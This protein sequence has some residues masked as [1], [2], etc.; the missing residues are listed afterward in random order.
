MATPRTSAADD[1]RPRGLARDPEF[2]KLWVGQAISDLGDQIS[3]LA[4]PLTALLVLHASAFE[5]GLLSAAAAAPIA[6]FTLFVG[7]WVDRLPRRPILIVA[8]VGR[9][10]LLAT[11]PLAFVLGIL[12]LAQLYVVAFLVGTLSVFFV[13]SYQA[14]LPALVGRE[15]LVEANGK[16]NTTQTAAAFAGP[17]IAGVL[18][19]V[20]VAPMP[21]VF[22]ALSFLASA[23]GIAVIRRGEPARVARVRHM[24]AEIAE[25]LRALLGNELMRTLTLAASILLL[26]I[27]AQIAVQVIFYARD[28]GL[29]PPQIGLVF[30]LGSV[31]AIAGAVV[32]PIIARRLGIGPSFVL[33]SVVIVAGMLGRSLAGGPAPVAIA[34]AGTCVMVFW[35]GGSLFNVNGPSLRQ[36]LTPTHLLGRVNASYRFIAWGTTP[37]GALLGGVLA[38]VFGPR[39]ALVA[40]SLAMSVFVLVIVRSPL[41]RIRDIAAP[42]AA[43]A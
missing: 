41:P 15:R 18:V 23:V 21:V 39:A 8:D 13:V 34:L 30:S 25:G 35:F 22:D 26:L 29:E 14:F 33:A 38:E 10:L 9:A 31:G 16:V 11:V 32:A 4:I 42:S 40:T 6:L 1:A 37:F 24:R 27:Q 17:G 28:L 43:P 2:L 7:V 5:M 36:A 12:S 3:L 20:F 19:Q